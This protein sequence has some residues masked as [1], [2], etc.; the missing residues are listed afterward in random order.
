MNTRVK[1]LSTINAYNVLKFSKLGEPEY[2]YVI[3]GADY[4]GK[5]KTMETPSSKH[6]HL[7]FSEIDK[8]IYTGSL[9]SLKTTV[10]KTHTAILEISTKCDS[11][12]NT[13]IYALPFDKLDESVEQ[14][15]WTGTIR[16]ICSIV[17]KLVRKR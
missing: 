13:A 1:K 11:K 7:L 3:V 12:K 8:I 17:D 5:Y 16:N 4:D 15:G 14:F 6:A 9:I 2:K 10:Q